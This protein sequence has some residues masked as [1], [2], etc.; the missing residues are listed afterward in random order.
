M[1]KYTPY[2]LPLIVLSVVFFLVFRWYNTRT[3]RQQADLFGEGVQIENL[4]DEELQE[5]LSG[6]GDLETVQLEQVEPESAPEV[7]EGV[8]RYEIIEDRARFS[9]VASL[10]IDADNYQVW[11]RDANGENTRHAFSLAERKGGLIGSASIPVDQLPVEV[12]VT[13]GSSDE[14]GSVLMRGMLEAPAAE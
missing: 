12:L 5:T 8:I 4:T 3:E 6:A 9:V 14:M 1:K 13:R 2:L 11:L 10:P 7:A